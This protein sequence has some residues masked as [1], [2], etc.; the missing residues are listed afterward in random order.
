MTLG[1]AGAPPKIQVAISQLAAEQADWASR[2]TDAERAV[3]ERI[4]DSVLE[5]SRMRPSYSRIY[6]GE[7]D[8]FE[9][10]TA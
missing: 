10:W 2:R 6:L 1:V 7:D 4:T 5:H 3:I 8:E 9:G